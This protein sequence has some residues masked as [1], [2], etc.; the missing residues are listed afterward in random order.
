MSDSRMARLPAALALAVMLAS[1]TG[2][3]APGTETAN[4]S[5]DAGAAQHGDSAATDSAFAALQARGRIAM[6][7]DQYTSTHLFDSLEDGGRIELQRDSDDAA[8]IAQIRTHLREIARA[9]DSGDFST[10]AFVHMREVPGAATMAARREHIDY[11][12]RDLPRG[13]EVRIRTRDP[14]ALRAVHDFL[15]FQRGDHRAGGHEH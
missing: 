12:V 14:E 8:G 3:A 2:G 6:G 5:A 15:A 10:P 9:F 13:A 11:E 4:G 1:C 7:V